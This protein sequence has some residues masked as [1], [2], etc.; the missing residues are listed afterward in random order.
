[1]TRPQP[2]EFHPFYSGY[3]QNVR[4]GNFLEQLKE[5][6]AEV[7]SFFGTISKERHDYTYQRGKWTI[8]QIIM[9]MADAERVM[10]YRALTI[11]RGD[12]KATL[13]QMDENLFASHVNI[14]ARTVDD[15]LN[16][17][18]V[19]REATVFLFRNVSDAQSVYQGNVLGHVITPRALGYIIVGHAIHH[20]NIVRD[21]YL[22]ADPSLR[23][24]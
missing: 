12:L 7:N 1:M 13:P 10:S 5:N 17:F 24:G 15:L 2:S 21:R 14:I 9:H 6:A 11:A 4:D 8:K 20:M 3:I 19:I 18:L 22:A 23:S 16:E